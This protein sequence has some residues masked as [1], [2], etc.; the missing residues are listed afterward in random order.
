MKILKQ[1]VLSAAF[2]VLFVVHYLPLSLTILAIFVVKMILTAEDILKD[3]E[4]N[5]GVKYLFAGGIY[6]LV[7]LLIFF[8]MKFHNLPVGDGSLL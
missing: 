6:L 5:K 4:G 8:F 2:F 1:L 7:F 3:K